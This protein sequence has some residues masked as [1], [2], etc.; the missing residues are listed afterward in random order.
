MA[1]ET[2]ALEEGLHFLYPVFQAGDISGRRQ[3][4]SLAVQGAGRGRWSR[5][6]ALGGP[7]GLEASLRVVQGRVGT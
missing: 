7:L 1:R 6:H 4:V 2:H 3:Y 5:T